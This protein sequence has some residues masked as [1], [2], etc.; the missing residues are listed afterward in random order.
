[1]EWY[2]WLIVVIPVAFVLGMALYAR[3]YIRD[4]VDYL[5]AGRVA[6]RFLLATG[7]LAAALGLITLVG[8]C[9]ANYKTGFA[10]GYWQTF[11]I[12]IFI[13]INLYSSKH[14]VIYCCIACSFYL[15]PF[16][17]EQLREPKSYCEFSR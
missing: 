8:N 15:L 2:N 9:E 3:R 6:G 4:V 10:V 5:S 13:F 14:N 16:W 7:D 1:M 17:H 12:P 11:F